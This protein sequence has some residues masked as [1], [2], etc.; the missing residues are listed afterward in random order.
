LDR[1]NVGFA[2]LTMN[3][4]LGLTAEMFE[5]RPTKSPDLCVCRAAALS[6]WTQ[7]LFDRL[8]APA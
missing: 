4:E 2:A 3:K 1:V 8:I 5:T 7:A 6:P